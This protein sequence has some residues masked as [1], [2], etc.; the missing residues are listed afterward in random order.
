MADEENKAPEA[1][2]AP[3]SNREEKYQPP[4]GPRISIAPPPFQPNMQDYR[5]LKSSQTLIMVANIAG[6]V[7]LFIG[8][9][10]LSGTGL[11][12]G[13]IG[14]RKLSALAKKQTEVAAVASRL[15]RSS[16]VGIV[17]CGVAL[18]LNAVSLYFLLPEVMQLVESGDYTGIAADVGS[19]AAGPSTTWG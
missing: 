13:I 16:V 4:T 12:C 6:P 17:I 1:P 2:P 8:G 5:E 10:L 19:G 11:I 7:S 3:K 15:R 18:V 14:Y 9:V